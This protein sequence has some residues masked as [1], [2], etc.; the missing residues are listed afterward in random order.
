MLLVYSKDRAVLILGWVLVVVLALVIVGQAQVIVKASQTQA[1]LIERV[2]AFQCEVG[3]LEE[4]VRVHPPATGVYVVPPDFI[5][6]EGG[7]ADVRA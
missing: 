3:E 5:G 7:G 1:A 6:E 4:Q 2:L